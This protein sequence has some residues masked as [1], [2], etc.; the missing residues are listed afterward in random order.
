MTK[1]AI[2][3]VT[4]NLGHE[5]LSVLEETGWSKNDIFA[6]ENKSPMGT[7]V[8]YGE[9]DD[10]DVYNL[11]DFDFAKADIAVFATTE[12]LTKKY[13]P[14]AATK[15]IK[16]I[17]CSGATFSD[18]SV[19]MIIWGINEQ[20]LQDN[21]QNIIAVPSFFVA[22]MLLP[23]Q[24]IAKEYTIK[25]IVAST[26]TSS[27]VYGREA[28]D[29]LFTQ[30]RKIFMNE[31]V[32]NNHNIFP[33]QIAFNVLPQIGEFMGD[34]TATEWLIN[35]Q[36]KKVLGTDVKIHANCAVVPSF[37]GSAMYVNVECN[38]DVDADE[39]KHKMQKTNG[40]VVFDKDNDGGYVSMADIQSEDSVYV[41]RIRQ[42]ISVENGF[43]FWS[44]VDNMRAGIANNILPI[45]K[46]WEKGI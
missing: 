24:N 2:V 9:D 35:A 29:E 25:R 44:V 21:P 18:L 30:T 11:E 16:I 17:D 31:P 26:Y 42:D 22:Q 12:E 20:K 37:I 13:L 36:S 1:L 38:E 10:I 23:L 33:K 4:E 43:S 14:K 41:S 46:S 19:P 3:G 45:I 6:V 8:S 39:I 7:M 27:S 28:M 15:K 32:T 34:E 5:I 40:V